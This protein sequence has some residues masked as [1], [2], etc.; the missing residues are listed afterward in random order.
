MPKILDRLVTQLMQ[1]WY[2]ET[3]A[4]KIATKSLQRSGNLK[5]WT[6]QATEK[7]IV[8]WE[9][10]PEERAKSRELK[11]KKLFKKHKTSLPKLKF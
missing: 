6:Q 4:Y 8:R 9:M 10:S 3:A 7:W 1:K 2:D 5:P 11:A